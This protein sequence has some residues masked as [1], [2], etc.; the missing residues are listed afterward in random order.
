MS[1]GSNTSGT[2]VSVTVSNV[3]PTVVI[4]SVDQPNPHFILPIVHNLTFKGS[5]TDPGW[6]DT[7][8]SNWDLGDG[9]NFPGVMSEENTEP[10]ATGQSE[11]DY[12][13]SV[14]GNYTVNLDITDDDGGDA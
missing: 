8:A 4:H 6:L 7:H 14:P 5:F 9:S 2:Q 3:Q 11:V 12:A 10:D 13:F 1:D